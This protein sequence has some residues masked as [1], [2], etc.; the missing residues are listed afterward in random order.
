MRKASRERAG[1]SRFMRPALV[2][3]SVATVASGGVQMLAPG[4]MLGKLDA[5]Q[6]EADRQLFATIGMFMVVMGGLLLDDLARHDDDPTVLLWAAL[7]KL[8]AAGAVA[9]GVKRHVFAGRALMVAGFDVAS[10]FGCLAYRSKVRRRH[11]GAS[12]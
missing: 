4:M 5:S 9:I 6:S 1:A 2:G 12:S 8:G 3:V 7:Q 10:G 11:A